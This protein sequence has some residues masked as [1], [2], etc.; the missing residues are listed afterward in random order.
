[1]EILEPAQLEIHVVAVEV[2]FGRS[3]LESKEVAVC[4]VVL[5]VGR[6][7]R[8]WWVSKP[9]HREF[10]VANDRYLADLDPLLS[11]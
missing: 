2:A 9:G 4:V 7:A 8:V 5:Q 1:M 6:E 3:P 11:L 10:L